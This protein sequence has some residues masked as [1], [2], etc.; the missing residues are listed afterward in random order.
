LPEP[1]VR[2]YR[3]AWWRE[4]RPFSRRCRIIE[5]RNARMQCWMVSMI[6][7]AAHPFY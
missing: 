2:T 3:L 1:Y 7:C 6:C 4:W 5:S